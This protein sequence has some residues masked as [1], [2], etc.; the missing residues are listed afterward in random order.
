MKNLTRIVC[1]LV[2][3]VLLALPS[4]A[5]DK[6]FVVITPDPT[7]MRIDDRKDVLDGLGM[8]IVE[9]NPGTAV[10]VLDGQNQKLIAQFEIPGG[11]KD[12]RLIK[13]ASVIRSIK[14]AF[15]GKDPPESFL[16]V[17]MPMLVF[18]SLPHLHQGVEDQDTRVL[19]YGALDD[20]L[21]EEGGQALRS[22]EILAMTPDQHPYGMNGRAVRLKGV[23]VYWVRMGGLHGA[24]EPLKDF[25]T[26]WLG[27]NGAVLDGTS[28]DAK[29]LK[30]KLF[31][32]KH[33]PFSKKV[34]LTIPVAHT[35]AVK[36][37]IDG[38][39]SMD[40]ALDQARDL[41]VSLA[42]LGPELTPQFTLSVTVHR[43]TGHYSTFGPETIAPGKS[44][45]G[46]K[47]LHDFIEGRS[48]PVHY[49]R[50]SSGEVGGTATGETG[51]V[52]PFDPV[53]API[54]IEE[55]L[56]MAFEDLKRMQATRRVLLVVGDS[57]VSEHDGKPGSTSKK[58]RVCGA[59]VLAMVK[60]HAEQGYDLRIIVLNPSKRSVAEDVAFFRKLAGCAGDRG[61]YDD[62]LDNMED[63]MHRA[64]LGS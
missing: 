62:G 8:V 40:P 16:S 20:V 59:R 14:R 32:E 37:V 48:V 53:N 29:L 12:A 17:D 61:H 22:D 13:L 27:A 45:P 42:K 34:D 1:V 63:L 54:D 56:T 26:N 38:S 51:R 3:T 25:Y 64:L 52:T 10:T 24:S 4:H 55:A 57:A 9:S 33:K 41:S 18:E 36:I 31:G 49:T 15:A 35:G 46:M 5:E 60:A 23:S 44:S 7:A 6:Q 19:L 50:G 58:D 11:S 2:L 39:G 30:E 47:N 28:I 43:G 21:K